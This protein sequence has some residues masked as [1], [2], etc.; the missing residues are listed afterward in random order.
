MREREGESGK[1]GRHKECKS[2][3]SERRGKPNTYIDGIVV[4]VPLAGESSFLFSSPPHRVPR[5]S[6]TNSIVSLP[7]L[8]IDSNANE[9]SISPSTITDLQQRHDCRSHHVEQG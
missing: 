1:N 6:K 7:K 4:A 9:N 2:W 3:S 5:H 8:L